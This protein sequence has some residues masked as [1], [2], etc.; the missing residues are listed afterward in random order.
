MTSKLTIEPGSIQHYIVTLDD[1]TVQISR[2]DKGYRAID[3]LY[4]R[5]KAAAECRACEIERAC[6]VM[7]ECC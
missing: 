7:D 5:G 6:A 1:R 3:G 4:W 2:F